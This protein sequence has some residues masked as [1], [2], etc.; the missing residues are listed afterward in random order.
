MRRNWGALFYLIAICVLLAGCASREELAKRIAGR[1]GPDP[2]IS[3][4]DTDTVISRQM[5]VLAYIAKESRIPV[6]APTNDPTWYAIAEWGF[7]IGREDCSSYLANSG[8][9][10]KTTNLSVDFNPE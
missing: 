10:A 9:L 6:N 2:I 7:N 8:K 5:L 3:A 1:W 4:D